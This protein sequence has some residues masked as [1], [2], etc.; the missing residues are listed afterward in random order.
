MS[1]IGNIDRLGSW[2]EVCKVVNV[3]PTDC[4][5][6][7]FM[8]SLL[9]KQSMLINLKHY[10][11][12]GNH[13]TGKD[14]TISY[15]NNKN[16][17]KIICPE[18]GEFEQIAGKH[19]MGAGCRVCSYV[20]RGSRRAMPFSDFLR[21]AVELHGN[22][23]K[24]KEST[25]TNSTNKMIIICP[26]HGEYEQ[27]PQVH[28]RGCGCT[29]CRSDK[30]SKS[31]TEDT[32]YF[33]NKS[34]SIYGDRYSYENT[35][36][37]DALSP[38]IVTCRQHGDF[39]ILKSA[40]HLSTKRV[41]CPECSKIE[42]KTR[43]TNTAIKRRNWNFEQPEDHKLIPLSNGE[44][45]MVDNEDFDEISKY[46]W[47]V[48][49]GGYARNSE[50]GSMHSFILKAPKGF[51]EDHIRQDDRL[52]NRKSNLRLASK[53]EN[54]Q[55]KR[56]VKGSSSIYKGVYWDKS[57]SKWAVEIKVDGKKRYL[58]RYDSEEEAGRVY[59]LN[60][61]K[62]FKQFAYLNFPELKDEYLK[63]K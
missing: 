2:C 53:K 21:K 17:I 35:V 5:L 44:F 52:D 25:Y 30:I 61:L 31:K 50:V 3:L 23:Y 63:D 40:S 56:P 33:I 37:V 8:F 4:Q 42:F 18:H 38:I 39:E 41:G 55:Y 43:I 13:Y 27:S 11:I 46:S 45:A 26:I 58:G 7:S 62:Y 57:R 36:Y 20:D 47:T 49:T 28:L 48:S 51:M 14:T 54:T 10:K 29:H 22:T 12:I 34:K 19:V 1:E 32:E 6:D 24:Y 60:A 15:I 16:K 9:H 59:D